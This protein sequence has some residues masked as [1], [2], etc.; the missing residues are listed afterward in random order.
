L[1]PPL[2][3]VLALIVEGVRG[4]LLPLLLAPPL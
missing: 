4:V 1:L 3:G 2:R